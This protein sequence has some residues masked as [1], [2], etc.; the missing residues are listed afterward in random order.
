MAALCAACEQ[1]ITRRHEFVLNGTECFHRACVNQFHRAR[2]IRQQRELNAANARAMEERDAVERARGEIRDLEQ[3]LERAQ[4]ELRKS[5]QRS[6]QAALSASILQQVAM[7]HEDTIGALRRELAGLRA[8]AVI[9][10]VRV[11]PAAPI[12]E[13]STEKDTRDATEIRFSLLEIDPT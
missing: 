8:V 2:S 6:H 1:P 4:Q 13:S 7:E 12:E 9:R 3:R 5:E 10:D 11:A